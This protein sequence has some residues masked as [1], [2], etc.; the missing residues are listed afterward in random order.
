MSDNSLGGR[1]TLAVTGVIMFAIG[2]GTV[3]Y[4]FVYSVG[5]GLAEGALGAALLAVG[6][7]AVVTAV[8]NPRWLDIGEN[9]GVSD[10][11]MR[12]RMRDDPGD[13]P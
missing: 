9:Y 12:E 3:A 1:V 7:G 2:A 10:T 6:G 8:L 5:L 11:E 4:P 13:D